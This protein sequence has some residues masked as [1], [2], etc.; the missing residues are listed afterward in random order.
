MPC[1]DSPTNRQGP[2]DEQAVPDESLIAPRWFDWRRALSF[3]R[4][5]ALY[6][7]AG[8]I[9]IFAVWIPETF[10]TSAT[11]VSLAGDQA[12]TTMVALGLIVAL[13]TGLFDLSVGAVLGSSAVLCAY[14]M[15]DKN[16]NPALAV[17]VTLLFGLAVGVV[18]S[19][20]V[21]RFQV[22]SF[23]ATLGMSSV[24]VAFQEWLTGNQQIIGLSSGYKRI[25][26]LKPL[27]IPIPFFYMLV[28]AV[29]LWYV[30]QLTPLGR[31]LYA[32]GGSREIARLAGVRPERWM[33]MSLVVS[34]FVASAAGVVVLARTSGAGPTLGGSYLLPVFAA[35][36]LGATQ[37]IPG[38]FNVWGTVV[39]V[40]V[41]ATGTKGLQLAG[42]QPWV[43]KLFYGAVL[44]IAVILA[45][46]TGVGRR[47]AGRRRT[48][49][50]PQ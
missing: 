48:T 42:L 41:L 18:N 28:L 21:V 7:W 15:V 20:V 11:F 25:A 50:V 3:Q 32:T 1:D 46:P 22:D 10:L 12:V 14:L 29:V 44:V 31:Y 19:I 9:I 4:I 24:L 13:A 5:S 8:I 30:L 39:S 27:G 49:G 33:S 6:I 23:I 16:W 38:R 26:T 37:F 45:G 35:S 47:L 17:V 43:D 2:M 36:F 40:F 34:A